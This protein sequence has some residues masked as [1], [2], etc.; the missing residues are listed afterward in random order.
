MYKASSLRRFSWPRADMVMREPGPNHIRE[1]EAQRHIDGLPNPDLADQSP[2]SFND[3]LTRLLHQAAV[4][5]I[6]V[7]LLPQGSDNPHF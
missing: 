4:A 5:H 1:L 3:L 2:I 6:A 7:T